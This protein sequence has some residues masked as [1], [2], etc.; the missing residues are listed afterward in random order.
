MLQADN[1]NAAA[2]AKNRIRFFVFN[3]RP[4]LSQSSQEDNT[5]GDGGRIAMQNRSTSNHKAKAMQTSDAIEDVKIS[6]H[7]LEFAIKMLTFSDSRKLNPS[8]FDTDL[9]TLEGGDR[10][11]FPSGHFSTPDNIIKAAN[12][13]VLLAFSATVLTLD[14]AFEVAGMKADPDVCDDLTQLRTLVYML[15]CA[16]AHGIADP[17]WEAR[18]KYA[19]AMKLDFGGL[20]VDLI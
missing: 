1:I 2:S 12:V 10:L 7:Q 17:R 9:V 4:K 16:Q 19:R 11:K 15:R 20:S 6:F 5:A 18:G 14:K 13:A 3:K 8:E